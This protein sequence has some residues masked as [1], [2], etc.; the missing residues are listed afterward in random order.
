MADC[1]TSSAKRFILAFLGWFLLLH[2][3]LPDYSLT[4]SVYCHRHR[5]IMV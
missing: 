1:S 2:K 3:A 4:E 5:L